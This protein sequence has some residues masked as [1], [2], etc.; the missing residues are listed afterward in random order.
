MGQYIGLLILSAFAHS[1]YN[2]LVHKSGGSRV[3]LLAMFL[4][5]TIIAAALFLLSR[6]TIQLSL[7]AF[8]IL[9]AASLFYVLYQF[10]VSKAY[11]RGEISRLYPLSVLSP[12]IVPVWAFVFLKESLSVGVIIGIVFT[13]LGAI[14]MKQ[15][16][17]S[18]REFLLIFSKEN[19]YAG[20][21]FALIASLMYSFG[22][23]LDKYSIVHFDLFS[24]LFVLLLC[25]TINLL[26]L[27]VIF[28]Q[29][30][31]RAS[32]S[33]IS[34]W[35]LFAAAIAAFVSFWS[36]RAALQHIPVS[37]AVTIRTLSILFALIIGIIFFKERVNSI[38]IISSILIILGISGI[39]IS[40]YYG[41]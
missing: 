39:N 32:I 34:L 27:T 6:A 25:M 7:S 28:E 40:L 18:V 4:G 14:I 22:S 24:Y 41:F 33:R 21:G 8:F 29:T 23:V 38:K 30:P 2:A 17:L 15:K 9:Y 26:V 19:L 20:A 37:V 16:K 35:H 36:F 13:T 3:F 31:V 10:F 5:A 11:E 12:M 1:S